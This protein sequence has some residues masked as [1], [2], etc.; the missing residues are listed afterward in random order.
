VREKAI[1]RDISGEWRGLHAGRMNLNSENI[2]C[3]IVDVGAYRFFEK[4]DEKRSHR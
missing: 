2:V 3:T 4:V 1:P